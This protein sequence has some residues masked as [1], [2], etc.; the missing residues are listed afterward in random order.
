[1]KSRGAQQTRVECTIL[2]RLCTPPVAGLTW[3]H[4]PTPLGSMVVIGTFPAA[5]EPAGRANE[6]AAEA[7][8]TKNAKATFTDLFDMGSST[9]IHQNPGKRVKPM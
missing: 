2:G 6:A 1:V 5:A 7:K 9:M 8:T 4:F 3:K